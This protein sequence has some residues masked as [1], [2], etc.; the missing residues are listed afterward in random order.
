MD[1]SKLGTAAAVS[2]DMSKAKSFDREIPAEGPA[3]MRLIGYIETGRHESLN[4]KYKPA[5]K[6]QLIFELSTPK[7]L[8]EIDGKKVPQTIQVRLNKG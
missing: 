5:L 8:I 3:L 7:H 2:E 4:P 6:T 1:F